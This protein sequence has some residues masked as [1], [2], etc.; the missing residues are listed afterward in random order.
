MTAVIGRQIYG[1][2]NFDFFTVIELALELP[3]QF[4]LCDRNY[5]LCLRILSLQDRMKLVVSL[6]YMCIS[7]Y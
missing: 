1:G 7:I 5:S 6:Y 4:N 2:R 3:V